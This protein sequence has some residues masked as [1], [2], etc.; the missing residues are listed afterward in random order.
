MFFRLFTGIR[1][2]RDAG[3]AMEAN[4]SDRKAGVCPKS[5]FGRAS[6]GPPRCKRFPAGAFGYRSD[7]N[8]I[9][10]KRK[11]AAFSGNVIKLSK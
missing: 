7:S 10:P 6:Y 4:G 8:P 5:A 3:I 2:I 11:K 1:L 9:M